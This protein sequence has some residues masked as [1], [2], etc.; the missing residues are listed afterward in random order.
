MRPSWLRFAEE[1][2]ARISKHIFTADGWKHKK[3]LFVIADIQKELG[4]VLSNM[5]LCDE[6]VPCRLAHLGNLVMM[7]HDISSE[8]TFGK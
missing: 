1:C 4:N 7:L 6:V 5:A 3:A 8:K 2:D